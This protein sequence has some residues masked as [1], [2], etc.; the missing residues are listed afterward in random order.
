MTTDS[1][2][3]RQISR[4]K[5]AEA[6][7]EPRTSSNLMR[8]D[9]I[10]ANGSTSCH[11]PKSVAM[12]PA[13]TLASPPRWPA[14]QAMGLSAGCGGH[15]YELV[16]NAEGFIPDDASGPL[17]TGEI[18][19]AKEGG[20]SVVRTSVATPEGLGDLGAVGGG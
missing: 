10:C 20:S 14:A 18:E 17:H 8:R 7:S 4:E 3:Q 9:R 5:K 19:R 15:G 12:P 16:T 6:E 13:S 2:R 1:S 11:R